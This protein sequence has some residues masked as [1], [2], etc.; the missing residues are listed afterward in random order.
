M[1]GSEAWAGMKAADAATSRRADRQMPEGT[2]K[3]HIFMICASHKGNAFFNPKDMKDEGDAAGQEV[4][5]QPSDRFD[6][7]FETN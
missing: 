4:E 1:L 2:W 5:Y 6:T 7:P 3:F